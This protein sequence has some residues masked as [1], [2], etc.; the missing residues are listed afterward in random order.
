MTQK[1]FTNS[2]SSY[3]FSF[4]FLYLIYEEFILYTYFSHIANNHLP[5]ITWTVFFSQMIWHATMSIYW[6]LL[7]LEFVTVLDF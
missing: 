7:I 5:S 2:A 1:S 6:I 4:S 3:M